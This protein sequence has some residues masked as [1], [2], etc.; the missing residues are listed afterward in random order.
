MLHEKKMYLC[1]G[2][3]KKESNNMTKKCIVRL[4][5]WGMMGLLMSCGGHQHE[6]GEGPHQHG[7]A[8]VHTEVG[9]RHGESAAPKGGHE[10]GDDVI[11]LEKAKAEAAGVKVEVAKAD[12]FHSVIPV[13]GKVLAAS[14]QE[15]TVT[16]RVNG[17]VRL[18]RPLAEG[19]AVPKGAA[20]FSI[21]SRGLQEG[22]AVQRARIEYE[23]A[24][25]QY[26]RDST[27]VIDRI[28]SER[29]YIESK[30][31]YENARLAYEALG[32]GRSDGT[33]VAAAEGGFVTEVLVRDGD[34]VTVGQ[35]LLKVTR[36]ESLFLRAEVPQ[37]HRAALAEVSSATFR[38]AYS[39]QVYDLSRMK[40]ELVSVGRSV[41]PGAPYI[42][43]TFRMKNAAELTPGS[44]A[45]I[46][47]VGT[48]RPNVISLPRS[49][50][51][52]EQGIYFV[53]IREDADCYR[54]QEVTLGAT[55]GRRTEIRSGLKGG[56][57]V[58]TAGAMQVKLASA[59]NSIPGHSHEH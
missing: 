33:P 7:E 26:E 4:P 25:E 18:L 22:D 45:E 30:T 57:Q 14:G 41:E 15:S 47:L 42:P 21:S 39:P 38:T 28:V 9:H 44:L 40:G 12:S 16:A 6:H 8:D 55:D 52:E 5:L 24:R 3:I 20:L 35:P 53:Y 59:S 56:E 29:H 2:K 48:E 51:V 36:S 10:H 37:R 31:A 43:V 32:K 50:L 34:H 17:L 58:V 23:A 46:W 11:V 54:K 19:M 13:S 1:R 27:L 49:A